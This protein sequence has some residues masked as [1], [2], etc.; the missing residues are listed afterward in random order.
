[1][2]TLLQRLTTKTLPQR[3]PVETFGRVLGKKSE[4]YRLLIANYLIGSGWEYSLFLF[5]IG[6]P[7]QPLI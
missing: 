7:W 4:F 3:L 6:Y 5:T 2:E 1:M